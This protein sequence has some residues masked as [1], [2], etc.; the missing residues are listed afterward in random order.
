[1]KPGSV[2][3]QS[4]GGRGFPAPCGAGLIE[5]AALPILAT[6]FGIFFRPLAG[7]ASLKR[8][9]R[10]GVTALQP[11]FRPLAGP[12]SLK[13]AAPAWADAG[14]DLFRPLA[15]PASLK[16]ADTD[17]R[18]GSAADFSGPLRGRPH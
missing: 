10:D 12:A 17:A 4:S 2:I 13:R 14:E 3:L 5:A 16:R 15:G 18:R 11:V 8:F 1:M 9:C 6:G 7:P